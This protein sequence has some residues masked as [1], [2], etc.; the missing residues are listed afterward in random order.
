MIPIKGRGFVNHA[1]LEFWGS[2]RQ[3][4]PWP[5]MRLVLQGNPLHGICVAFPL[6]L[7]Q[8]PNFQGNGGH[9]KP[10]TLASCEL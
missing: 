1:N 6:M 3:K 5:A 4:K 9:P 7:G 2:R 8:Y 10:E